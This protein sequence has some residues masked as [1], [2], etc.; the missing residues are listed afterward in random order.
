MLTSLFEKALAFWGK[1]RIGYYKP[2]SESKMS[3]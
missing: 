1:N 2:I 3:N